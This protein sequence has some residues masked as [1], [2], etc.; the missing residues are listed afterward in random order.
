MILQLTDLS[1]EPLHAQIRTQIRALI[2]AGE[3]ADGEALPS[4]RGLAKQ[5]RV[6]VITVQRAYE[7][8]ERESLIQ[9]RR[10][11]G[12]FVTDISSKRKVEMAEDKLQQS[13]ADAVEAARA[14]GL[15]DEQIAAVFGRL[16]DGD[17]GGAS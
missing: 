6:S 7:D 4:I 5:E 16:V 11:K 15:S 14:E 1:S 12:F 3:L 8:L 2:R 13:L 10:G 9:A 17:R